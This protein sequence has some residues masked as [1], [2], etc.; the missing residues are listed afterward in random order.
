MTINELQIKN[1]LE[2]ILDSSSLSKTLELL[3]EVCQDK[4]EHIRTNWQ[5][6][7]LAKL[8]NRAGNKIS[9]IKQQI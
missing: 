5:D 7:G 1:Q 6:E 2:T 3:A 4:A 9:A 8:W